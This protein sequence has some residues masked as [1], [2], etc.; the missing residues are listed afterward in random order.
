MEGKKGGGEAVK[1][2]RRERVCGRVEGGGWTGW[3]QQLE[4]TSFST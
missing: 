2:K 4:P 3:G 1:G